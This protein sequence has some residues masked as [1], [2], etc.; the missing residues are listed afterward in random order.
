MSSPIQVVLDARGFIHSY[1]KPAGGGRKDL[2]HGRNRAFRKHRDELAAQVRSLADAPLTF[3]RAN[4]AVASV[5]L[6]PDALAKSNRPATLLNKLPALGAA[7]GGELLV[8]VTASS[9]RDLAARIELAPVEPRLAERVDRRTGEVSIE[10]RPGV[11]RCDVGAIERLDLWTPERRLSLSNEQVE[12]WLASGNAPL[13]LVVHLFNYQDEFAQVGEDELARVRAKLELV[14]CSVDIQV[15]GEE[16]KTSY[17]LVNLAR[18]VGA[19]SKGDDRWRGRLDHA[20]ALLRESFVVRSVSVP[21]QVRG[22]AAATKL[23]LN[24]RAPIPKPQVGKKYPIVGVVDGG[25]G[26]SLNEWVHVRSQVISPKHREEEHGTYI[27]GI[28]VVGKSLNGQDVV[29]EPDG[30]LLA[31]ICMLP[32]LNDQTLFSRYFPKTA[33]FLDELDTIVGQLSSAHGIRVFNFS[34][35]YN[36]KP[37]GDEYNYWTRRLDEISKKHDIVFVFSAGNLR[38]E[39]MRPEWPDDDVAAL[40]V[41]AR[42]ARDEISCPA[43]SVANVSVSAV[44]PALPGFVER[45]PTA[46]SRRGPSP[47]GGVKPDVAHFGGCAVDTGQRS[48]LLSLS[49]SGMLVSE[50]GTSYSAPLVAKTLASYAAEIEGQLSREML[51]ALLVHHSRI[52]RKLQ[53]DLLKDLARDL[54]GFG[55]PLDAN[56]ALEGNPH[57]ATILF[58][59]TIP[60]GQ[61]L[62]FQF[63]WPA[64]LTDAG[65]CRGRGRLTLVADPVLDASHGHE[66]VRTQLDAHVVQLG[67]KRGGHFG[68]AHMPKQLRGKQKLK[69]SELIRH[70]MKW[71]P[72]KVYHFNAP[73][74][75]GVSSKWQF[76]VEALERTPGE[77]PK[78]GTPFVAIL[79]IEDI[80]GQAPV[81]DEMRLSLVRQGIRVGDIQAAVRAKPR[82]GGR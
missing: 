7:H 74:G 62:E 12:R 2:Y 25:I 33:Q 49:P 31:D 23:T 75:K 19:T 48:G 50:F 81:F 80:E 68:A 54:V 32:D 82:A 45:V 52:P 66:L 18:E 53:S 17:L 38:H 35:N 13:G 47:F 61:R 27:G 71:S 34:I 1:D 39:D 11:L 41:L 5:N 9:L 43:E 64:S 10:E 22:S 72:V 21:A 55:V 78:A 51:I 59:E 6:S 65:R 70:A 63:D 4:V 46:Y 73:K 37:S 26:A 67:S 77:L 58:E 42:S 24:R 14:E 56:T 40:Q 28:L 29:S 8:Q 60:P 3:Q 15:L 30:C 36:T 69:E 20:L 16:R 76:T 57:S 44:N 79:T